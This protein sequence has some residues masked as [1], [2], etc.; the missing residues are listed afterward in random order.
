MNCHYSGLFSI[1]IIVIQIEIFY[2]DRQGG[3][4]FI[5]KFFKEIP[6]GLGERMYFKLSHTTPSGN[7]II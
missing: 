7:V 5:A 6:P 4:M 1:L 2:N 3:K